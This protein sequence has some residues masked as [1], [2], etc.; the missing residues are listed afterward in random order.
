MPSVK[1]V[2]AAKKPKLLK[3]HNRSGFGPSGPL[4]LVVKPTKAAK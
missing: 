3:Q 1:A 2:A 4:G